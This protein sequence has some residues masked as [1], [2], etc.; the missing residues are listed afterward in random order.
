M[1][2]YH[3]IDNTD[4]DLST[5]P[6]IFGLQMNYLHAHGYQVISLNKFMSFILSKKEV[7]NNI[8]VL[9]FDDGLKDFHKFAW[10]ILDRHNF[11]ATV[12]V[13][14]DF[15][16]EKSWWYADY[17]LT[18]QPMLNW[19]ELKEV[20]EAGVDIQSHGCSHRPLINLSFSDL[21]KE[22]N[23]SKDILEQGLGKPVDYFCCPQGTADQNVVEAIKKAGYK[24][25]TIGGNGL[26]KVGDDPYK[27][28]RQFL[29][30]ISIP[31]ER[32]AL[33]SIK[34]CVQGTFSWYVR[35]KKEV[36]RTWLKTLLK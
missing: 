34:A 8:V 23:E 18:P 30:I 27:I 7:S 32:T 12:F 20:T 36:E 21:Q 24:G 17:G 5:P 26:H 29:D 35:I 28:K 25:A 4:L 11:S 16:G 19:Q 13:P 6:E 1:L 14:T 2:G 10:P 9:T 31:D 3:S 22:M 15:I 33:I